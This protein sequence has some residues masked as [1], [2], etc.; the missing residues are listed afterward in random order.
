MGPRAHE[1]GRSPPGHSPRFEHRGSIDIAA[2]HL[3]SIAVI[4]QFIVSLKVVIMRSKLA[5]IGVA[6]A[7][8][9]SHAAQAATHNI[10]DGFNFPSP[11]N[12]NNGWTFAD[13]AGTALTTWTTDWNAP[14]FTPGQPGWEGPTGAP[15]AGWA[16]LTEGNALA[17]GYDVMGGE[18]LTHGTTNVLYTPSS[19]LGDPS[20]GQHSVSISG[21]LHKIRGNGRGGAWQLYRNGTSLL[22]SGNLDDASL[23]SAG[24]PYNLVTNASYFDPLQVTVSG[25]SFTGISYNPGDYFN[26]LVGV[27]DFTAVNLS[28]E[29]MTDPGNGFGPPPAPKPQVAYY[30]FEE[31]SGVDVL[32]SL[33]GLK[34]GEFKDVPAGMERSTDVPAAV[35]PKTG[36]PNLHSADFRQ[37]GSILFQQSE[38]LFNEANAGGTDGGA[39]L[40]WYMKVPNDASPD[41]AGPNTHTSIFWTNGI[42]GSDADRY[43]IFWDASFT[44][45]PDSDRFV[46]GD[47]RST[48][49]GGGATSISTPD[50]NTGVPLTEDQWHH[51]AIVRTDNTPG[52][53]TDFDFSWDWYFDGVVSPSQHATTNVPLPTQDIFGWTIAGRP[54]FPFR[55]LIDEVRMTAKTL[56]PAEFLNAAGSPGDF[57]GDGKVNGADFLVWQRGGSPNPLSAGDLA[58]WKSHFGSATAASSAVPEPG[59]LLTAF[60]AGLAL[61]AVSRKSLYR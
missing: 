30:R 57:N 58:A 11:T 55:A 21:T 50:H 29:S 39:T 52:D 45:A 2:T 46:S 12:P 4:Y 34:Q 3:V 35:I 15:H 23:P 56:T 14:D 33:S 51:V 32:D 22:A 53:K 8:G 43:N 36:A 9:F 17:S 48:A 19:S 10:L 16:M 42:G 6:L 38:F 20:P 59:I 18:V 41:I 25:N 31:S 37:G 49:S 61:A 24:G 47:F 5:L 7:F 60:V 1:K 13:G 54:G 27:N 44:G 28:L 26:L 40:E